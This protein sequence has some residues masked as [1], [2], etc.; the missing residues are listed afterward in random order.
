MKRKLIL[1]TSALMTITLLAGCRH[2]HVHEW[3]DPTYSWASDY[4]TCTA[5]RVCKGDESHKETETV[6]SSVTYNP[7][8]TCLEDGLATYTATFTNTEFEAQ[9]KNVVVPAGHKWSE[10]TYEWAEDN[11]SCTASRVCLNDS[12][13]RESET[14]GATYS[15]S[16]P[17]DCEGSGLGVYT[18]NEFT[19]PVFEVQTK[20]VLIAPI[21]HNYGTPTYTWNNDYTKCTAKAICQNDPSH[22]LEET[23]TAVTGGIKDDATG[24]VRYGNIATFEDKLFSEQI[25]VFYKLTP[26]DNGSSYSISGTSILSGNITL[27]SSYNDIPV[28]TIDA[29]AFS[30]N[31]K[32]TSITIPTSITKIGSNAFSGSNNL[33]TINYKG[34]KEQWF[35]LSK[36][37][38]WNN[39][40]N[41][42]T[43]KCSDGDY[44][45]SEFKAYEI[46]SFKT[47][48]ID[49]EEYNLDGLYAKVDSNL[50]DIFNNGN[51][52]FK[53]PVSGKYITL[54]TSNFEVYYVYDTT[55]TVVK[56][57]SNLINM[58]FTYQGKKYSASNVKLFGYSD[59]RSGYTEEFISFNQYILVG[60]DKDFDLLNLH[61]NKTI[62]LY[63]NNSQNERTGSIPFDLNLD[64]LVSI[65]EHPFS[66][67]GEHIITFKYNEHT[68]CAKYYVYDPTISNIASVVPTTGRYSVNVGTTKE[69]FLEMAANKTYRVT[70]YENDG[71]LQTQVTLDSSAFVNVSDDTFASS[72]AAYIDVKIND[73]IGQMRVDVT[74]VKGTLI[75]SYGI[76][77]FLNVSYRMYPSCDVTKINIYDDN[78]VIANAHSVMDNI[79]IEI[80]GNYLINGDIMSLNIASRVFLFRID[81]ENLLL[82][83]ATDITPNSIHS[84][85]FSDTLMVGPRPDVA[86]YNDV[87]ILEYGVISFYYL[88]SGRKSMSQLLYTFVNEE[89][90]IIKL[91]GSSTV[92]YGRID[93]ENNTIQFYQD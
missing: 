49:E 44:D 91:Y 67:I 47:K 9:S 37:S 71:S 6:L 87:D 89:K 57:G 77:G 38:S 83:Q 12:S 34:T 41:I 20:E 56:E 27:L 29:Q 17:A 60:D 36:D 48:N 73:Q 24:I 30:N 42:T 53:D 11:L 93:L 5:L 43:I 58:S 70:Y 28:T 79:D 3:N 82:T 59:Y 55:S 23:V 76:N 33:A 18:T 32:I 75:K 63:A 54:P 68:Y 14:V 84:G 1:M 86:I 25:S 21:N 92:T 4:S 31:T 80:E 39:N 22:V 16:Y 40:S 72:G 81:D 61:F 78:S 62:V 85:L 66:T 90:T 46:S 2:T 7:E 10:V 88:V 64:D 8:A 52:S 19:N 15:V 26:I 45:E 51:N 69:Q 13:H 74:Q 35:N 65:D 50:A